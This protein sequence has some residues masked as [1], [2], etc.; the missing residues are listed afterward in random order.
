MAIDL[1]RRQFIILLGGA[2]IACFLAARPSLGRLRRVHS[3]TAVRGG[4]VCG[5]SAR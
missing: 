4:P 2:T 1:E 3:K 5:G